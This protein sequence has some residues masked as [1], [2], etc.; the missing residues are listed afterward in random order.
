[1][2]ANAIE[3]KKRREQKTDVHRRVSTRISSPHAVIQ[4]IE[5]LKEGTPKETESKSK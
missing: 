5:E 4:A 3:A 1:L 2:I